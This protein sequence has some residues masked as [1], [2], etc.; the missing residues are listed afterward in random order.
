MQRR[1]ALADDY[2]LNSSVK[3]IFVFLFE[4]ENKFL[5]LWSYGVK[6]NLDYLRN[7]MSLMTLVLNE[8]SVKTSDLLLVE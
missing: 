2:Y 5:Q 7:L 1:T 8:L 6:K 4:F 3:L